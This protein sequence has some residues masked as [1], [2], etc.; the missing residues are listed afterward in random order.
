MFPINSPQV[1]EILAEQ[2]QAEKEAEEEAAAAMK[3]RREADG[4]FFERPV[5]IQPKTAAERVQ[6]REHLKDLI[7]S[8]RS[9]FPSIVTGA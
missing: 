6:R 3:V 7:G 1:A 4:H 5:L 2:S 8:M 9:G